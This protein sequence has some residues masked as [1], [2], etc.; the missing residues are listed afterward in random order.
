MKKLIIALVLAVAACTTQPTS[1]AQAVFQI[2][3]NYAAAL[4]VAVTY[5]NLP[6]CPGT[7]LCSD[8]QVVVRLQ[9]ADDAASA[10]LQGA[11]TTVRSGASGS[12]LAIK[13]AE[14]AVGALTSITQTLKVK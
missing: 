12:D 4:A 3:S 5:K 1:P 14:Q 13:A 2:E 8:A 9:K 11:Q 10:L 7:V 6:P